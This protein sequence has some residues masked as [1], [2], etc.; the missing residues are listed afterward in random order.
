MAAEAK[1]F[2]WDKSFSLILEDGSD[3]QIGVMI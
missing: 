3:S 1:N 2:L